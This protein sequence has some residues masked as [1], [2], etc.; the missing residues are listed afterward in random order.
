MVNLFKSKT[1][2]TTESVDSIKQFLFKSKNNKKFE[3]FL[4][5]SKNNKKFENFLFKSKNK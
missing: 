2:N 1:N 3:N 4:F 5:K